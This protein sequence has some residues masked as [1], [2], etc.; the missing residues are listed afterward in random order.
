MTSEADNLPTPPAPSLPGD[1]A[2]LLVSRVVDGVATER[3]WAAFEAAAGKDVLAWREL[4]FDLAHTQKD[5]A[6]LTRAVEHHVAPAAHI[7]LPPESE[8]HTP[9]VIPFTH[10][11]WS[12]TRNNLGWVAA[13]CLALAAYTGRFS[14]PV[15]HTPAS[16]PSTASLV[17]TFSDATHA[18]APQD[19]LNS[20]IDRG[21]DSGTVLG[22]LPDK[23]M[24]RAEPV[25]LPDGTT[26]YDVIYVRQILERTRMPNLYQMQVGPRDEMGNA[27]LQKVPFRP[28]VKRGST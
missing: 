9:V 7:A 8:A 16:N 27:S 2:D 10:R 4:A 13:A 3:D 12:F 23:V 26:A 20:Y 11:A 5:A 15:N 25:Q 14:G 17:P 18:A 22:E 6:A 1:L 24:V 19:L 28:P 21:M